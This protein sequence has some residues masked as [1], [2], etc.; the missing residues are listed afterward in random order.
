M[1]RF[2][3]DE[4]LHGLG[5]WLRAAGYDTVIVAGGLS[6]RAIV[7]R[8]GEE[9]RVLLTKDRRLAT[10][11]TGDAQVVLLPG[12]GIDEV[13]RALRIALAIDW[14]HAPFT[15]CLVDN[16]TLDAAPPYSVTQVPEKVTCRRRS[17]AAVPRMR[18]PLLA[19]KP[20]S[21]NAADVLLSGKARQGPS[22]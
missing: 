14:Q 7:A 4:M 1:P 3:C 15:R 16:R 13:A 18:P 17:T 6:D 20:C 21:P 11:V 10:T 2:L 9:N 8:C 5:R 19:G 22:S 12:G